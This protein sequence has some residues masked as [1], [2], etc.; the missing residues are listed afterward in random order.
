MP[1]TFITGMS[2]WVQEEI[3]CVYVQKHTHTTWW[4]HSHLSRCVCLAISV[5]GIINKDSPSSSFIRGRIIV[6]SRQAPQLPTP[7]VLWAYKLVSVCVRNTW[8]G[9][10]NWISHYSHLDSFYTD[11]GFC[12]AVCETTEIPRVTYTTGSDLLR[13]TGSVLRSVTFAAKKN[14]LWT[15]EYKRAENTNHERSAA[16]SWCE[17]WWGWWEGK[18]WPQFPPVLC[19]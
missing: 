13:L 19:P 8:S 15:T 2:E 16:P 6:P 5:E 18:R 10:V 7:C 9:C 1:V 17:W 12:W 4:E 11:Y 14:G 3:G